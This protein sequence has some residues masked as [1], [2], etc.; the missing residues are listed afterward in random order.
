MDRPST[1]SRY[2]MLKTT[3]EQPKAVMNDW[4]LCAKEF[5]PSGVMS[6]IQTTDDN[7]N[8]RSVSMV[9][10]EVGDEHEYLIPLSRDLME[11]EIEPMIRAF[12][13][14]HPDMDFEGE[15]SSADPLPYNSDSTI[16]VMDDKYLNLCTA[17]AKQQHDT[18]LK[19]RTDSGWRYGTT[20]SLKNKTHPLCRPWHELPDQF[21]KIDT[22]QPQSLLDLLND[23]GYSVIART[24]LEGIMRLLKGGL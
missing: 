18:W 12:S 20:M 7:G 6:T 5:L 9:H 8:L 10:R 16:E 21:K 4:F 19:D 23:Q 15:A 1:I 14:R 22:T 17:W 13:D 3:E 11:N 2:V 24:E